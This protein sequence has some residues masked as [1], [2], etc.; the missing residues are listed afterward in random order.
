MS[1]TPQN[2]DKGDRREDP[3]VALLERITTLYVVPQDRIQIAAA[4]GNGPVIL[5]L[6]QRLMGRLVAVLGGWLQRSSTPSPSMAPA[7]AVLQSAA[8]SA[9][10]STRKPVPPVSAGANRLTGPPPQ[11]LIQ[12]VKVGR[13]RTGV[14]LR[15]VA[16]S[17]DASLDDSA[18][19][20]LPLTAQATRQWLDILAGQCRKADW[21]TNPFPHWVLEAKRTQ[22][23]PSRDG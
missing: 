8:Q 18:A 3:Q 10:V 6:T 7:M 17:I 19:F 5:W 2:E 16:Q 14:R 23:Q 11:W 20:L 21:S 15:F 13:G 22:V 1:M 12:S 4:T 9:A